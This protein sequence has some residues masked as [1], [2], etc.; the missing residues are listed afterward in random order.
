MTAQYRYMLSNLATGEIFSELELSNVSAERGLI[1]G[2]FSADLPLAHL[3]RE[4]RQRYLDD[5]QPGK[6]AVVIIR[7]G[8]CLGEWIV[9]KRIRADDAN[10]VQLSGMEFLSYLDHRLVTRWDFNQVEQFTIAKTIFDH[11]VGGTAPAG[12]GKV[13]A[14]VAPFTNS[15]VK[16][17]R[18]Y[19]PAEAWHGQRLRELSDVIDG[20]DYFVSTGFDESTTPAK[21]VRELQLR[22][23]RAGID[24]NITME[25][26]G[27]GGQ[28]SV[29]LQS[30]I[31]DD[32]TLVAGEAWALGGTY[33]DANQNEIQT[34]AASS[35][36][37][38]MLVDG[39]PYLQVSGS[40]TSVTQ[41][42]TIQKH[43]DALLASYQN[44]QVPATLVVRLDP[45]LYASPN[46]IALGDRFNLKIDPSINFP[47]GY[48]MKVRL[49]GYTIHPPVAG[50]ETMS[51]QVVRE[52]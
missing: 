44:G 17:D 37:D 42:A 47:N 52:A 30:A 31:A 41:Q 3:P 15:G 45:G 18:H 29:I 35:N 1:P 28:G 10:P 40:W 13:A 5:T 33:K 24:R 12:Y 19:E 50:P 32:G 51:L 43:A 9:W 14:T 26:G 7:D 48:T 16:R 38:R 8:E 21:V 11:G 34:I 23:P 39:Y 2:G 6:F 49:V 27:L 4:L 46:T 20:F 25:S 22:Y 36:F